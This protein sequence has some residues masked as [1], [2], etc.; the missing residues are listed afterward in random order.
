MNSRY[1][2]KLNSD[3]RRLYS[4]GNSSV[5]P[6]MVVY[7]MKNRSDDNRTGFTVSAKL[8]HAVVRNRIRR[9]LR[10]LYRLNSDSL[11][12]GLDIVIVARHRSVGASYKKLEEAFLSAC[13]E[14]DILL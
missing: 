13:R 8:G 6:Y 11:K 2:L 12:K 3:F 14:L 4:K 5:T 9:Q 10:E 7:C 1:T